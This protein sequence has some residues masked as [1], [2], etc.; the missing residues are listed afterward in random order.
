[1][2][3][4]KINISKRT[5]LTLFACLAIPCMIYLSKPYPTQTLN[6]AIGQKGSSYEA[7]GQKLA[8]YF[9]QHGLQINLVETSGMDE[10]VTKLDDDNS[11]INAAF[12][13]A[14]QK[15]PTYWSG[16]LSIGSVQY[17][18]IWLIYRGAPAK[19]ELDLFN[20][21]IA[22]GADGTNTQTLFKTLAEA[23]GYVLG[24]QSNFLKLKHADAVK[25]LNS[26]EIDAIFIV[27]GF[28]SE[29]VQTLLKNPDNN[30]YSFELADAYTHQIPY[31]SK[32]SVPKGSLN[33]A[34]LSPEADK[35][36]LATST[37][38]LVEE[39]THPYIQWLLLR[40]V[41]E[42]N[43]ESS[44]FFA[45]PN[46]FPAQLDTTIKLSKIAARYYERGFPELTEHMPWWLAIYLDRIWVFVLTL[47]AVIVPIKEL[48]SAINDL[49]SKND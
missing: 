7:I 37:T 4:K 20:R 30:I 42:I 3:F 41:R 39:N 17:A 1:M 14:G 36:I 43:N 48:W 47:L 18:P 8:I 12:M 15:P 22:I 19:N 46:F 11:A 35:T 27:D 6:L 32:L 16:L 28:D 21:K 13:S 45:P 26:G 2:D 44:R 29:N 38:L 5:L 34:T 33:L 49:R 23:R 10:A 40:G 31:L 9:K 25:Q 24:A